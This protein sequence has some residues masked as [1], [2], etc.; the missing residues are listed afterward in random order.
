[1]HT[2]NKYTDMPSEAELKIIEK[3]VS[4]DAVF[5]EKLGVLVDGSKLESKLES[6]FS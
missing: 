5:T 6:F 4:S 1:G 3:D 2:L